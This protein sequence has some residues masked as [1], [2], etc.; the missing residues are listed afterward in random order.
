MTLPLFKP[1]QACNLIE[2]TIIQQLNTAINKDCLADK[3]IDDET[4]LLEGTVPQILQNLFDTYRAITPQTLA[5]AKATTYNHSRPIL[6]ILM[7]T[8]TWQKPL[9]P[10]EPLHS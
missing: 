1:F 3:L 6:T 9:M 2:R 5:A 8:P 4:G 7:N 10:P